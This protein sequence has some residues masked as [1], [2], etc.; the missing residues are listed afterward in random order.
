MSK[1]RQLVICVKND[2]YPVSLE[3]RKIYV[4]IPDAMAAKI[5]QRRVIDESG[6]DYLYPADYFI[7]ISLPQ[8][9][10]RAVLT[11]A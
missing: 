11:A 4:A 8:P 1:T 7:E 2:G 9:V 6:E 3:R 10:R 5:G